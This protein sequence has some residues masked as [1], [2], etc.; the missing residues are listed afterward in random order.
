[1]VS[2]YYFDKKKERYV[3]RINIEGKRT[4][5]GTF[6]TEKEAV[7][8][9]ENFYKDKNIKMAPKTKA[10][11]ETTT[12]TLQ[13]SVEFIQSLNNPQSTKDN[14]I[15]SLVSLAANVTDGNQLDNF[16]LTSKEL[17]NKY[18]DVN[19]VPILKDFE[20]TSDVIENKIT[21]KRT[22]EIISV[23]TKKQYY[24]SIA[25]LFIQKAGRLV[26]NKELK[27]QYEEKI[28]EF[29]KASNDKRKQNEP[30]RANLQYPDF[31]WEQIQNEYQTFIDTK[32]F[33]N[34]EKG[35]AEL[36]VACLVGLYVLQR[37]RRVQDYELL[38]YYSKLP[39]A[40][41]RKGKNI[42]FIEKDTATLYLDK[43]KTRVKVV[44]NKEKELLPT[45]VK[46]LNPRLTSLLKDYIKKSGIKD[47]AKLTPLERREKKEF[48]IFHKESG[49]QEEL[50]SK[51][52]FSEYVSKCLKKVYE[53]KD[54]SV[55][56]FR[57][58]F[59]DWIS[60]HLKEY[61][62]A[63]LEEIAIDV[64]DT[65]R[66]LPTN[67]RYRIAR[68]ENKGMEKSQIDEMIRD[69]AYARELARAG[70]EEEA[71]I[72][73]VA[74]DVEKDD[75]VDEVVSPIREPIVV[76]SDNKVLVENVLNAL[77]PFLLKM[78]ER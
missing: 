13:T 61:T 6:K 42:I 70:A 72:G 18:K 4:N 59:N 32:P 28:K 11:K 51:G 46:T 49:T 30:I 36:R 35:R 63:Q 57:H 71:S 78:L 9:V 47:M 1:M 55:N 74:E 10:P 20:K 15:R 69:D 3:C 76:N 54:L 34:T 77:R 24:A 19:L 53:K 48:Y 43:F 23:D 22:G 65:P 67:L 12:F 27:K 66:S 75:D 64:G 58:S 60:Q 25:I 31:D 2:N 33:T 7:E 56:T 21:N 8:A 17:Q 29:D 40:D 37:P 16:S 50:Y 68:Q 45:Y 44:R 52:G 62:D 39:D 41:K 5:I 26:V 38:Q 14:W 73:Q